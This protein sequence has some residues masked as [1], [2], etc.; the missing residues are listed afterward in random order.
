MRYAR[1]SLGV[2]VLFS[3]ANLNQLASIMTKIGQDIGGS[4]DLILKVDTDEFLV[5][6][7]NTTNTLTTSFSDYLS[8]FAR[9]ENHPL[10]LVDSSRVGYLQLAMASEKVCEKDIHYTPDKYPLTPVKFL[11]THD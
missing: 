1:D 10:R 9:N 8:G 7:D 2:N 6:H 11:G 5:I 4:S 3:D